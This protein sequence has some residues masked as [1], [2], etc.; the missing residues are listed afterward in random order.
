MGKTYSAI[1]PNKLA[2]CA[3]FCLNSPIFADHTKNQYFFMNETVFLLVPVM[4][5]IGLLYTFIKFNW[6]NKQ[7][8]G[9]EKMQK[10]RMKWLAF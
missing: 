5:I 6:V 8:P 10:I 7:D 9:S 4:G 1:V 2:V 3:G